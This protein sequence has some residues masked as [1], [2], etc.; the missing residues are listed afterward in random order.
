MDEV[1]VFDLS[2]GPSLPIVEGEGSAHAVI[3]PGMGA[4]LRSIHR[5]ELAEGARTVQL[6]H[7][8]EAVYYV[9]DGSGDAVD[10]DAGEH[11]RLRPGS[12]VHVEPGTTYL[13][14]AG[15]TGVSIV[16]GPSPP[17]PALYDGLE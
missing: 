1:Q 5:I 8:S 6:S 4:Q 16:G 2:R 15:E 13:L 9:I 12:M 7:P 11:Q 10:V 17:D 14:S 3:W